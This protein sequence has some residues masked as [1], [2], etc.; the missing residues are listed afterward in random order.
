MN[1]MPHVVDFETEA[2]ED[3]PKYPPKPVGV[4]IWYNYAEQPTYYAFGHPE[5]NNSTFEDAKAALASIWGQPIIY[6][7]ARF[8]TE[9]ARVHMGLQP[10]NPTDVHDT[11]YLLFLQDP[12]APSLALKESAERLLGVEP[13]ERD[14]LAAFCGGGKNWGANISKAPG[15][16]VAPYANGDT[17]RT[18]MLF[19]NLMPFV[20]S[21]GMTAAYRRE[22]LLAPILNANENDGIRI[23]LEKLESDIVHWDN[24]MKN[25]NENVWKI[26]GKEINID[27]AAEL[28]QALLD[29]GLAREEDFLRTEKTKKIST[30]KESMAQAI[31]DPFLLGYLSY[32]SKLKVLLGTFMHPWA[33]IARLTNGRVHPQFNQVRGDIY[34]TRTGRLSSSNPNFQN[35]PTEQ[36]GEVPDGYPA[37]PFMREYVLPDEGQII[38]PADYNGQE[39]RIT[40]HFAEGRAAEIYR[41][42]P[43]ADFHLVVAKI[44]EEEA[45]LNLP[46]KHVKITGFSLIYGAGLA[47]LSA[48]L[49]VDRG[50]AASIKLHYFDALPGFRELM[51]DVSARGRSGLPV[52]T[53]GGRLIYSEPPKLVN[54]EYWTFEYKLLN[55]L[56]QG[57]AGDQIKEAIVRGGYRS[58]YRRFLITVHDENVYSVDPDHIEEEVRA[59]KDA[60]ENQAGWDVPFV[61]EVEYGPNWH[62]LEA[63]NG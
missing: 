55:H 62:K 45:G 22:Q 44:L 19:E 8:D 6:H 49:G 43:R 27:S 4:S 48:Q 11:M 58:P 9:V 56:I 50:R 12:H 25:L 15:H 20:N 34:G 14:E 21:N 54:G 39:M 41:N 52:K 24:I 13:T 32:R 33:N 42:D 60:M 30:S 61:A 46:R 47:A 31:K 35:V 1:Q 37:L 29:A 16:I 28:A 36:E 51:D 17:R 3:R 26:L 2:I 23:D 7:N 40:A 5:G 59:I 63:Y 57:S 10:C 53:W 18:R 38:L